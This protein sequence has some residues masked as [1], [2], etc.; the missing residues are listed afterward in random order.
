[1]MTSAQVGETLVTAIDNHSIVT[2][3]NQ[4][5]LH[6]KERVSD[7]FAGRGKPFQVKKNSEKDMVACAPRRTLRVLFV[8]LTPR[9]PHASYH[10]IFLNS[11]KRHRRKRGI[12]RYARYVIYFRYVKTFIGLFWFLFGGGGEEKSISVRDREF[13]LVTKFGRIFMGAYVICTGIV[14]LNMLVTMMN[15]SFR[16]IMLCG[17]DKEPRKNP[18]P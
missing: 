2:S 8:C 17:I 7:S 16:R 10:L 13:L 12:I 1:M 5:Y 4:Q 11:R 15:N 3:V 14:A 18:L 6:I 9:V